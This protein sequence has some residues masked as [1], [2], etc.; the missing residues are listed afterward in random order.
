MN[1]AQALGHQ[2]EV[3]AY[4]KLPGGFYISTP[5]GHYNPDW[6]IVF[7]EGTDIKHVYFVIAIVL[8][9]CRITAM[10]KA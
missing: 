10:L 3:I 2:N 9:K 1:F 6:V 4:T 8:E 7:M 5:A